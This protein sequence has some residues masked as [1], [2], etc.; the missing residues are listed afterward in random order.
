[1]EAVRVSYYGYCLWNSRTQNR[2]VVDLRPFIQAFCS[3][4]PAGLRNRIMRYDQHLYL[5][6]L[7]GDLYLLI[8]TRSPEVTNRMGSAALQP[9]DIDELFQHGEYFGFAS[10]VLLRTHFLA[11]ASSLLA[12]NIKVFSCFLNQVLRLL[13]LRHYSFAALPLLHIAS[14]DDVLQLPFSGATVMDA[15]RFK[16][17]VRALPDDGLDRLSVK[18]REILDSKTSDVYLADMRPISDS[19]VKKDEEALH[20]A[21]LAKID[22]NDL[23]LEKVQ[24][25]LSKD[26]LDQSVPK[27]IARFSNPASWSSS[28]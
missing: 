24:E 8:R 2:H 15:K 25:F 21:L 10:Y 5:L 9:P 11:L 13:G 28:R 14:K 12:P 4:A 20:E 16:G 18:A 17:F 23:L 22:A 7:T 27:L 19:I 3:A 26:D 1:M 6:H